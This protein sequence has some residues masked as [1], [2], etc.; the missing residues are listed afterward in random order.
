MDEEILGGLA[1]K[2][3]NGDVRT[4]TGLGQ[5]LFFKLLD[6]TLFDACFEVLDVLLDRLIVLVEGV[7]EDHPHYLQIQCV[8]R[9]LDSQTCPPQLDHLFDVFLSDI[10]W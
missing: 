9:L 8:G 4:L 2:D 1:L 10:R 6:P 7:G 3:D 5:L